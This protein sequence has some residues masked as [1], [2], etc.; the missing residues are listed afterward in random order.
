MIINA[1]I[2]GTGFIGNKVVLR[3][4]HAYLGSA[5]LAVLLFHA[6]LGLKLALSI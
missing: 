2:S 6:I 3:I 1:V 5:A 4:V